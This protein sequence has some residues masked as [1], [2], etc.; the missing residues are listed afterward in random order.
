MDPGPPI[1]YPDEVAYADPAPRR[2][3]RVEVVLSVVAAIVVI[4]AVLLFTRSPGPPSPPV[5]LQAEA[6]FCDSTCEVVAPRVSLTWTPP[7][8]GAAPTAYRIVRDGVTLEPSPGGDELRFVDE[9]VTMGVTYAYAVVASSSEGDSAATSVLDVS[10]PTPPAEAAH[11]D[12]VYRVQLTVRAARS[13]GA[14]FGIENPV[15]GKRHTDRWSFTAGCIGD[16]EPCASTWSSLDGDIEPQ[17]SEEWR[18]T[19][20]GR[21]ARCGGDGRADAPIEID[22]QAMDVGVVEGAWVVSSFSGTATVSFRCPGFPPAT[23][24]VGVLGTA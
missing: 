22:L 6:S 2:D 24:T 7:E 21:A 3:R 14:A 15:A 19:V 20:A 17:G 1:T 12:G 11:L 9:S 13:I 16:V 4:G 18:G 23:A 5:G 8:S 10:V